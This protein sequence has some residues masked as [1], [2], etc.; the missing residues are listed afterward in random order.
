VV[1]VIMLAGIRSHHH[2]QQHHQR[3]PFSSDQHSPQ[4]DSGACWAA[5]LRC[6]RGERWVGDGANV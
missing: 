4:F 5:L 2:P 3:C 6:S 1:G